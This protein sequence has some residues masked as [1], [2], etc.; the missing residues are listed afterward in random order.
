MFILIILAPVA[1]ANICSELET[2]GLTVEKHFTANYDRIVKDYWSGICADLHPSCIVKPANAR[3]MAQVVKALHDVDD[4][5]AVKSGGHM[6]SPGFA[7]VS[8]GLLISTKKLNQV[9]YNPDDKTAFV[10][11]GLSWEDA[12]QKLRGTGRALVGGRLGGVGVGGLML[13][14]GMSFLS[15]Q[16]GWAA[17][18]VVNYEVVLANGTIVNANKKE[19]A[20]LF[21][22]LKGGGNNFGIVT[23]Y[24]LQTQPQN[25]KVWGGEFIYPDSSQAVEVMKAIRDFAEYYPDEKAGIIATTQYTPTLQSWIIFTFYDGPQPP[26]GVFDNFTA[27]HP[28][29]VTKTWDSYDELLKANDIHILKDR[30]YTSFTETIPVPNAACGPQVMKKIRDHWFNTTA[31]VLDVPDMI[32]ALAL[33]PL[34]R[35]MSRE[36][37]NRGGDLY[38]FSTEQDYFIIN[39]DFSYFNASF[40]EKIA[41]ANQKILEG[42]ENIIEN[43]IDDGVLPDVHRPLFMNEADGEQDYWGRLEPETTEWA[44]EVRE[45]S[46]QTFA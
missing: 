25:H 24:R 41:T 2:Q 40:D 29:E 15:T 1:T 4:L 37:K 27:L 44:R 20:D 36:V 35:K 22:A 42:H 34:P 33:Q 9:T 23:S 13:G 3:E 32:G 19:N 5:F 28:K 46:L 45:R 11:P 30:R 7:S 38:N 43:F 26:K 10:G 31:T 17:N 12:Q 14:G 8:D 6:A 39:F 18:N 21:G 16:Y